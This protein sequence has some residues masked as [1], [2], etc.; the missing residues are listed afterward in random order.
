MALLVG[1]SVYL[2]SA[3]EGSVEESGARRSMVSATALAWDAGLFVRL[4]A[5]LQQARR[6][7]VR[8]VPLS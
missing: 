1:F 5:D 2:R 3:E 7:G 6:R 8:R 4:R